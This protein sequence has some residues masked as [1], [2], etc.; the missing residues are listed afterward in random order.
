LAGLS[1]NGQHFS[2]ATMISALTRHGPA[3]LDKMREKHL[4][5][6]HFSAED[7]SGLIAYLNTRVARSPKP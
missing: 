5:W 1:A 7:M 2:G 4:Q 6:P 3:M